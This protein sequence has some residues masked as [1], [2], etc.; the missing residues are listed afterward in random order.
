M[1]YRSEIDGLRAVSIISVLLYHAGL[2]VFSGGYAGV[3][4]FFVISG[5]LIT[6]IIYREMTDGTFTF[7]GFYI[8][9]IRRI[10]P[11]LLA[12]VLFTT[13]CSYFVLFPRDFVLSSK[14]A[15]AAIFSFS[16]VD[17][18]FQAFDMTLTADSK[19]LLHTWSLAVEEQFY[20]FFPFLMII[21]SK[22]RKNL[23]LPFIILAFFVSLG[24]SV[25]GVAN[26][27]LHA[28][29]LLPFRG[30]ELLFGAFCAFVLVPKHWPR[31][32]SEA[33]S[34]IGLAMIMATMV[35]YDSV[36]FPGFAA[37][38][39]VVGAGLV[40][41]FNA[42]GLT[43]AGRLLSTRPMVWTGKISYSLY[44][45]HGP[46]FVYAHYMAI[47][48]LTP[49]EIV[50]LLALS[51]LLGWLSW[52]Y[53]ETPFRRAK[54]P[55]ARIFAYAGIAAALLV[56]PRLVIISMDGIPQ[57]F[58]DKTLQILAAADYSKDYM[59]RCQNPDA[60]MNDP[61]GACVFGADVTPRIALFGD[62]HGA[63]LL[64][65]LGRQAAARDESI[66]ALVRPGCPA[67]TDYYRIAGLSDTACL[68]FAEKSMDYIVDTPSID[69]AVVAGNYVAYVEGPDPS[70]GPAADFPFPTLE[71]GNGQILD[72]NARLDLFRQRFTAMI[73]RMLAAGKKVVLV[74]PIPEVGY[75]VTYTSA[76]L[77][78]TD[79]ED[80]F[81]SRPR[82]VFENRAR[83]IVEIMDSLGDKPN[84]VRVDPAASLCDSS[85]CWFYKDNK[86]L[87]LDDNHLNTNGARIV[88]DEVI[89]VLDH[90]MAS[91]GRQALRTADAADKPAN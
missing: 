76:R 71:N 22:F 42:N 80:N 13:V 73:D 27:P 85:A 43:G 49:V 57:R 54:A 5:F 2:S 61:A 62:S 1:V 15:I 8:R 25:W 59:A 60:P 78:I 63:G 40:I 29:F 31:W 89:P 52:K 32:V 66:L 35:L 82:Q 17:F 50:G 58:S 48:K 47:D 4:V 88:S 34:A 65:E 21:V 81:A 44:L 3:D 77:S 11:A 64:D 28:F 19:P 16:N 56:V 67:V 68:R 12:L 79:K 14:A 6:S 74:Y 90:L 55:P 75:H 38:L 24:I 37:L 86:P 51:F 46:L 84:L 26:K 7:T 41:I 18:L 91:S 87:Y 69:V 45:F 53:V 30:Y 33:G 70:L 10:I 83:D 9:R 39:P 36:R 23:V 20:F 72:R